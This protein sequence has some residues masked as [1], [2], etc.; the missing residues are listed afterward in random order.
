MPYCFRFIDDDDAVYFE[1]IQI[2]FKWAVEALPNLSRVHTLV[3]KRM[4]CHR[5][6]FF[7]TIWFVPQDAGHVYG[8]TG[9]C[10]Y[11]RHT[12]DAAGHI[13]TLSIMLHVSAESTSAWKTFDDRLHH[14]I[15]GLRD[16][17]ISIVMYVEATMGKP[18]SKV[19]VTLCV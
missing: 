12:T 19:F 9:G 4:F 14:F 13:H 16:M 6:S 3:A 15:K 8:P 1:S 11:H 7:V 5:Y 18:I 2:I 17:D 10:I